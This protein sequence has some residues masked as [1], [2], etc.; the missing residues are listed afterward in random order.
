MTTQQVTVQILGDSSS[1]R[2]TIQDVEKMQ[3]KLGKVSS[4]YQKSGL[5]QNKTLQKITKTFNKQQESAG[6]KA[7]EHERKL[8]EAINKNI[9]SIKQKQK[10][11]KGNASVIED[12]VKALRKL[13]KEYRKVHA[14]RK[15]TG[16]TS[17]G[18]RISGGLGAIGRGVGGGLGAVAGF[19][20]MMMAGLAAAAIRAAFSHIGQSYSSYS[21]FGRAAAGLS[22][23]GIGIGD[24]FTE[25]GAE[26]LFGRARMFKLRDQMRMSE[27]LGYSATETVQ[28]MQ[29][30]ARATGGGENLIGRT[31]TAQ[32]YARMYGGDVGEVTG[33][34]G[35]LTQARGSANKREFSRMM[36]HA[37]TAG[38][39]KSRAGEAMAV[40]SSQ[41]AGA[42]S[43][44][45]GKV[46]ASA[47]S[48]L[49]AWLGRGGNP[50]LQGARGANILGAFDSTLKGVGSI[51]VNQEAAKA[52]IMQ[53]F[54]FGNA[55]GDSA[56]YFQ[57]LRRAQ[58]G[59]Y[60]R[61]E[62]LLDMIG[63]VERNTGGGEQAT[64][65]L[66]GMTGLSMDA[67]D[68]VRQR[69][70][71]GGSREQILA[72]VNKIIKEEA[73]IDVQTL[74]TMKE[75]LKLAERAAVIDN[76]L[77]EH[78]L[79]SSEALEDIQDEMRKLVAELMPSAINILEGIRD[80]IYWIKDAMGSLAAFAGYDAADTQ[81]ELDRLKSASTAQSL[82]ALN[83][84][85]RKGMSLQDLDQRL[86]EFVDDVQ[87]NIR[88]AESLPQNSPERMYAR[89]AAIARAY[90]QRAQLEEVDR[91]ADLPVGMNSSR[92]LAL[93]RVAGLREELRR[94]PIDTT[95]QGRARGRE[96]TEELQRELV[97]AT[98]DEV[99]GRMPT[100]PEIQQILRA[101]AVQRVS[102]NP[103][104]PAAFRAAVSEYAETSFA[105][106]RVDGVSQ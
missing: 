39:D 61:P 69:L 82:Q 67:I 97:R 20:G 1:F 26:G 70:A 36:Q 10:I 3:G 65:A 27:R 78:G 66:S 54:G 21:N 8:K 4:Q 14:F 33:F 41:I 42:A 44:S 13:E 2:R 92:A 103:D 51:G 102:L 7:L 100:L 60:G 55:T 56:S 25:Y 23:T 96:L 91:L 90:G 79:A 72:D 104:D 83:V 62:N 81:I 94:M 105:Q 85:A 34:M 106:G 18:E 46:D 68:A 49:V 77:V 74:D 31:Q 32:A 89:R 63:G 37:M 52:L 12:E 47:I 98:F 43:V 84:S 88:R 45:G 95:A 64:Y 17:R 58:Q 80:A 71:S 29:G 75:S 87:A 50:A 35:T 28:Q 15:S 5:S 30:V 22:G 6:K 59:V 48:G 76:E 11:W 38:M 93:G 73:P 19:G 99:V 9:E 16:V 86:P 24:M 53:S 101:Q 57:V 40:I